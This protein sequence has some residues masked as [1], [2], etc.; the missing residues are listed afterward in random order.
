MKDFFKRNLVWGAIVLCVIGVVLSIIG[1][2]TGKPIFFFI[3]VILALPTIGYLIYQVFFDRSKA[4]IDLVPST[5]KFSSSNITSI[6]ADKNDLMLADKIT[7]EDDLEPL[8]HGYAN[9]QEI[10]KRLH[11]VTNAERERAVIE[12]PE[13]IL[14]EA[15]PSNSFEDPTT[16]VQTATNEELTRQRQMAVNASDNFDPEIPT[17]LTETEIVTPANDRVDYVETNVVEPQMNH[18]SPIENIAEPQSANPTLTDPLFI[19]PAEPVMP[20]VD[21]TNQPTLTPVDLTNA[22]VIHRNAQNAELRKQKAQEKKALLSQVN[23]ERYL[24]RYFIETAAC[25][26]LD[27]TIYKDKYGIAP[28]NKFAVNKDTG[29]PEYTMSSTKGRLYKFCAYLVDAERFITHPAFY[30]DFITAVEQGVPLARISETL[31]PLYRKKYKKDFILNLSN[32]ED[33]DNVMILVYN[34]YIL[35]NDNF[36]DIFTHVPFEIPIAF[37]E[38]NVVDYLKDPDLQDRFAER[39]AV[40]EEMGIPTFWD[41]LFICFINSIKQKLKIEQIESAML[42]DYKK[43]TRALKRADNTRRKLLKKAS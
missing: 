38:N 8:Y 26:M 37:N 11:E 43:I 25:F 5:A 4:E 17:A 7:D 19:Q 40:L 33:W 13:I 18:Q 34:N 16:T 15:K 10:T 24:Q 21:L 27:R 22:T 12:L 23:L 28:Y 2:P 31:H 30:D 14:P 35:N 41:A 9:E 6:V 39:Y 3:G 32:R 36:K 20:Q 29:L 42:R 1:I